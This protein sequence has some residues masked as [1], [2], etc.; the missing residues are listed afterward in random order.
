MVN[1]KTKYCDRAVFKELQS[2]I[3]A[4]PLS[5]RGIPMVGAS[6]GGY[7]IDVGADPAWL[8]KGWTSLTIVQ[9]SIGE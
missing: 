6:A 9:F 7:S 1:M 5:Q 3:D 4:N 8:K 2:I